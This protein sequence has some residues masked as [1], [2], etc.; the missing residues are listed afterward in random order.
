MAATV[1]DGKEFAGKVRAQVAA[2]VARL[3]ADHGLIPGLAVVLALFTGRM[4]AS[5]TAMSP[6]KY[7]KSKIFLA[8]SL[9]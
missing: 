7:R 4:T 6:L 3:R 1:I 2:H 8:N 5:R 9:C